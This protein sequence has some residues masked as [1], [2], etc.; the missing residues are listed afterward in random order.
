MGR[1]KLPAAITP[2]PDLTGAACAGRS[3]LF[4][5]RPVHSDDRAYREALALCAR[6]PVLGACRAWFASLPNAKRPCG[7][8][9][10]RVHR[11][12]GGA[13]QALLR[14]AGP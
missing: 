11:P 8:V 3:D 7:V 6:C 14:D 4:E 2:L 9:A 13:A 5:L 10:G 12:R 1:A